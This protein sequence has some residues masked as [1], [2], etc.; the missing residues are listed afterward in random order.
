MTIGKRLKQLLNKL[1]MT[2]AGLSRAIGI[3]NV[4]I[5]RY[6]KDK[7]TP[8]YN[9]LSKIAESYN[10]NINW[11]INGEG[12]IFVSDNLKRIGAKDYYSLPI[13]AAVS[14]GTPQEIEQAEPED[15]IL[16]DSGALPGDF[17]QYFAFYAS[18]DSM[19]PYI[20]S[21]DVVIVKKNDQW[22]KADDRVCVVMVNGEVTLKKVTIFSEGKE[23]LLS[24]YNKE[25]SPIL[26][27]ADTVESV[28]LIGTAIMAVRNL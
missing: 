8:D 12:T 7:T 13:V 9:F 24:P 27:N 3:S 4:V 14:C 22:E 10:V 28:Y 5:N 20:S 15:F 2:Q 18:G 23:I 26:I 25:Y 6:I 11:L 19:E 1:E 21:G 17:S 16:M